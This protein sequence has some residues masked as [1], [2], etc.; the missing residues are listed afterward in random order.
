MISWECFEKAAP[1]YLENCQKNVCGGVPVRVTRIKSTAYYQTAL[2]I[3]SRSAQKGKS[4][5]KFQKF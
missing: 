4:I 5:L 3:Y 2:Q 1:K